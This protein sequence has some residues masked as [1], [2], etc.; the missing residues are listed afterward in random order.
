MAG[1]LQGALDHQRRRPGIGLHAGR[2]HC[3]HRSGRSRQR[4]AAAGIHRMRQPPTA[5]LE[6]DRFSSSVQSRLIRRATSAPW[7]LSLV[8]T[9]RHHHHAA[10]RPDRTVTLNAQGPMLRHRPSRR[11]QKRWHGL[12]PGDQES[13][14]KI[15]TSE[16]NRP[17]VNTIRRM[18]VPNKHVERDHA[19]LWYS[20]GDTPIIFRNVRQK[21]LWSEN[22]HSRAMTFCGTLRWRSISCA[23]A[24][25]ARMT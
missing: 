13:I 20:L 17:V 11:P 15:W 23:L 25:R 7:C 24:T 10:V 21:W 18:A 19:S 8:D 1:A 2:G 4:P 9:I 16:P 14:R 5:H 22:P 6:I 12:G 3:G